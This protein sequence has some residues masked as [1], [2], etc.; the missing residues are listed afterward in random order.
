MIHNIMERCDIENVK[1]VAKVG[2]TINDMIEGKKPE[3]EGHQNGT[4][5]QQGGGGIVTQGLQQAAQQTQS[6]NIVNAINGGGSF[7]QYYGG[8]ANPLQNAQ[9]PMNDGLMAANEALGG[10]FGTA[11]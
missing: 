2:D 1:N 7:D 3:K 6:Q 8:P 10:S 4:N 5:G 11:F 9:M